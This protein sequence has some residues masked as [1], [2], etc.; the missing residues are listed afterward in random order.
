MWTALS[1]FASS[2]KGRFSTSDNSFHSAP[3]LLLISELCIFGFSC[4]IFLR[5]PRLQTM[6]AFIG[7]L[8]RSTSFFDNELLPELCEFCGPLL[9]WL[10]FPEFEL[11]LWWW[12]WDVG[13]EV[14]VGG[15]ITDSGC[16]VWWWWW[17]WWWPNGDALRSCSI[18]WWVAVGVIRLNGA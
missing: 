13:V 16:G 6:K 11:V 18:A 9:L 10:L 2:M 15:V 3:N 17:W 14:G 8:T 1:L 4:A 5:C 7:L 12:L